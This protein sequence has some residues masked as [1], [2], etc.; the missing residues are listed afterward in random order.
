MARITKRRADAGID[1][2]AIILFASSDAEPRPRTLP[3][4]RHIRHPGSRRLRPPIPSTPGQLT[5]LRALVEELRD[6]GM[7]D[8]GID[9]HGY[10]MATIPATTHKVDVPVIGFIAHVDTS[11]EMS[12]AGVK[13]IV[14]R[15]YDG[16]DLILPD[17]PSAVLR[18]ADMPYARR[19]PGPR[20]RHGIGHDAAGS[21]QQGRRRGDHGGGRTPAWRIAGDSARAD[22]HRVHARRGSRAQARKHFDVARF[23]ARVRL[24]DG[25][26]QRAASS[27]TRAS[28]PTR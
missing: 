26:R 6:I 27:S 25:R 8:A 3:P 7:L 22:S 2:S 15:A 24:H 4:L 28:R 1:R 12:G 14:H 17:D 5:L 20:H 19:V 23:G 10:V 9:E 13:P 21:R 18:V 16:R 11:P